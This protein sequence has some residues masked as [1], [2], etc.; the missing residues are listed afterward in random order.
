MYFSQEKARQI[1]RDWTPNYSDAPD[2]EV[3]MHDKT[4]GVYWEHNIEK[5][6]RL[7]PLKTFDVFSVAGRPFVEYVHQRFGLTLCIISEEEYLLED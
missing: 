6:M 7:Q 5:R 4:P 3:P 2:V 1:C